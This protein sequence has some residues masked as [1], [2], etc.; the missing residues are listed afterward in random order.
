V[1]LRRWDR[2]IVP[3]DAAIEAFP[4]VI[5]TGRLVDSAVRRVVPLAGV[6][7]QERPDN[8]RPEKPT[9]GSSRWARDVHSARFSSHLDDPRNSL[10]KI[11]VS[12]R[13]R[14]S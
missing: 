11:G 3:F 2:G 7:Y 4:G 5:A 9:L 10:K 13:H 8:T 6:M 1:E 14:L 12:A